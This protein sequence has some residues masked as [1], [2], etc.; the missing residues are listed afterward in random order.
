M[1]HASLVLILMD[2]AV[3]VLQASQELDVTWVGKDSRCD[4]NITKQ[5]IQ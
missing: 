3:S 4:S 5:I 1:V 2:T